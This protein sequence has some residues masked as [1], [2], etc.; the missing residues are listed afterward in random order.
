LS[1]KTVVVFFVS[2]DLNIL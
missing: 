2:R 1:K